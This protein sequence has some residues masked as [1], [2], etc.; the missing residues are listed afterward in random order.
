[1]E[2]L[3]VKPLSANGADLPSTSGVNTGG[4]GASTTMTKVEDNRGDVGILS[5]LMPVKGEDVAAPRREEETAP[6]TSGGD[7]PGS[8]EGVGAYLSGYLTVLVSAL[9]AFSDIYSCTCQACLAP[10]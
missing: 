10:T 9:V 1:M 8:P 7:E 5:E 6:A 2:P 4:E 3:I